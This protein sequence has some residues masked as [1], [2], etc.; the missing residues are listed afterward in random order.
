MSE[1]TIVIPCYEE[2]RRLPVDAFSEQLEQDRKTDFLF[3]DDGSRD[4]TLALLRKLAERHPGRVEVLALSENQ[5]KGEAIRL[6]VLSALEKEPRFVGYLDADLATPLNEIPRLRAVLEAK[7][8]VEIVL[9]SRVQLLGRSISRSAP[10]HYIGR[11]FATVASWTLNLAVYDTQC[12]AKIFR[13]SKTMKALFAEPFITNWTFD[14]E[15]IARRTSAGHLTK[16]QP[17]E[18][19]LYELPLN[20]WTGVAGSKVRLLDFPIALIG[21]WRIRN[22]YLRSMARQ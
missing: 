20:Q 18:S 7:P 12:G 15:L 21:L 13:T 4:G 16:L 11:V 6:G 2:A 1:T 22:R 19:A 9:G 3:V 17:I 14:V 8:E 10:R 5:G